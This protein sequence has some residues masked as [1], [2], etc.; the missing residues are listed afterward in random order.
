MS[1]LKLH[2]NT[3]RH[4]AAPLA[5]FCLLCASLVPVWAQDFGP[6]GI[7]M[8]PHLRAVFPKLFVSTPEFSAKAQIGMFDGQGKKQ[9]GAPMN[10]ALGDR[11]MRTEIDTTGMSQIPPEAR[12]GMKALQLDT[13]VFITRVDR[14]KVYLV[15]PGVQEYV[16]Y[17]IAGELMDEINTRSR[18]A[19]FQ[20]TVI[21]EETVNGQVCTKIRVVVSEP[22]RPQEEA[23]LW[24]AKNLQDFPLRMALIS[25]G[26]VM[27][28]EFREVSLKKPN[29]ALFE[30][31]T[32]YVQRADSNQIMKDAVEK[33]RV[34]DQAPVK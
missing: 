28:F 29:P 33:K 7:E 10:F 3:T 12:A 27:K 32:N 19:A 6:M 11:H 23:L 15:F 20:R 8:M 24:C 18:D 25:K 34:R 4:L 22:N 13:I 5:G 17:P 31:P 26:N 9:M 14:K 1:E 21:G 16:E 2:G 30:V